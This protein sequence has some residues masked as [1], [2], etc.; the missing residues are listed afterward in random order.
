LHMEVASI[1]PDRQETSPLVARNSPKPHRR[2]GM[3]A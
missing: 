1:Q 3:G 2:G